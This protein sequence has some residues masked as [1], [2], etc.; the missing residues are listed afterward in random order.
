[1][2]S[3]QE[4]F[5]PVQEEEQEEAAA[6]AEPRWEDLS[7]EADEE[8]ARPE[9]DAADWAADAD[10]E[11]TLSEHGEE[12]EEESASSARTRVPTGGM[13][14]PSA[15]EPR[16]APRA[17]P[18]QAPGAAPGAA[19]QAAHEAAA[20]AAEPRQPPPGAAAVAGE[21]PRVSEELA[22][23]GTRPEQDLQRFVE[24]VGAAIAG[25]EAL[26]LDA[27]QPV[28]EV[29]RNKLVLLQALGLSTERSG[30]DLRLA[31]CS[32]NLGRERQVKLALPLQCLMALDFRDWVTLYMVT[33][34]EDMAITE[35]TAHWLQFPLRLGLL[36][37][38]SGGA[39]SKILGRP[40]LAVQSVTDRPDLVYWHASRAKNDSHLFAIATEACLAAEAGEPEATQ[41]RLQQALR[42]LALLNLDGDNVF[43]AAFLPSAKEALQAARASSSSGSA[44]EPGP[45][46]CCYTQNNGQPGLTGRLAYYCADWLA[47]GGYDEE[48]G[49][50]GTGYQDVDLQHRLSRRAYAR[51]QAFPI[52][53]GGGFAIPQG[54]G[55]KDDRGRAKVARLDPEVFKAHKSWGAIN[56]ANVYTMSSKTTAGRLVRNIE[57]K[58]ASTRLAQQLELMRRT[59]GS[60][61]AQTLPRPAAAAVLPLAAEPQLAAPRGRDLRSTR[62]KIALFS[63]G[64]RQ[65]GETPLTCEKL[66]GADRRQLV[67]EAKMVRDVVAKNIPRQVLLSSGLIEPRADVVQID[68]RAFRDQDPTRRTAVNHLGFHGSVLQGIVEDPRFHTFF[69]KTWLRILRAAERAYLEEEAFAMD[70]GASAAGG[71]GGGGGRGGGAPRPPP[72][73]AIVVVCNMGRHRSVGIAEMLA[74]TLKNTSW[75]LESYEHLSRQNWLLRTC[76]M[77]RECAR[78]NDPR[79]L[80]AL[81]LALGAQEAAFGSWDESAV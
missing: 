72:M 4:G 16:W 60:S 55:F 74:T 50:L 6:A 41:E 20:S 34:A 37:V 58:A 17:A 80:A 78:A 2:P 46:G 57:T 36:R 59:V 25:I 61:W 26:R 56:A 28:L 22:A 10:S 81:R 39:A 9:D 68:A 15:A 43:A 48:A 7:R 12:E 8:S 23:A 70:E 40:E 51:K 44:A 1:M 65:V 69:M 13:A 73:V 67:H 53:R 45:T 47:V 63:M 77:C 62:L 49:V 64:L 75:S 35:W 54:E 18:Q 29:A 38:A 52:T 27:A 3:D 66:T 33:Y 5:A 31:L 19:P 71:G 76:N 79:R 24:V 30:D 21:A 32:T 42:Q 11:A 14:A